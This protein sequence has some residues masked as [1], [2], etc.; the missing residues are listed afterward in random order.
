[1][2]ELTIDDIVEAI[3]EILRLYI[4]ASKLDELEEN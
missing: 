1:M 2:D 3:T 4:I